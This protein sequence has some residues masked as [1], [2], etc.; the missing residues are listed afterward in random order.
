MKTPRV[1][2]GSGGGSQMSSGKSW[3]LWAEVQLLG[4]VWFVGSEPGK[5]DEFCLLFQNTHDLWA[6]GGWTGA[7]WSCYC[8]SPRGW[9]GRVMRST[10]PLLYLLAGPEAGESGLP[11]HPVPT[12]KPGA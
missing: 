12:H 4:K 1:P 7:R 9:E 11:L 2:G 3:F 8:P 5:A 6:A 10:Q